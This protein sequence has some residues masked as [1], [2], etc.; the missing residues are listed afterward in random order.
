MIIPFIRGN[1]VYGSGAFG[2]M[3]GNRKHKGIDLACMHGSTV[4]SLTYGIVTKIGFPYSQVKYN[5][6]SDKAKRKHNFKRGLRYV[7][8][9]FK[10]ERFRY[11]YIDSLVSVGDIITPFKPIGLVQNLLVIYPGITSHYHFEIKTKENKYIDPTSVFTNF[12]LSGEK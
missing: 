1:D 2:A 10:N 12:Y 3:R 5:G 11:F 4:L 6:S 9:T 8:I 7:E